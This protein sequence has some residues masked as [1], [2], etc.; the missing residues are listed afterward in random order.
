[1]FEEL[2]FRQKEILNFISQAIQDKGYPPTLREIG[3]KFKIASTN[4]VH[5]ILEALEKKGYIKRH[6]L[7]SRGIELIQNLKAN[8]TLV[9]VVGRIA[10]GLPILAVENIETHLAVDKTFL[11]SGEIFSL[12]VVGES[13]RDAGILDGDYVLARRQETA[14]KGD[15]V[16]A[17]IGEEATVKTYVPLKNM[18]RLEPA[19]PDFEPIIVDKKAPGFFIAGKVM[20]LMRKM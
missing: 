16:V 6:P 18:I 3:K 9:P 4:G 17:V 10:A 8:F 13:M 5:T 11:P 12:K 2:T 7:L 14:E 19:N 15:I 1:M 20:G